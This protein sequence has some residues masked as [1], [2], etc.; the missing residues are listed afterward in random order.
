MPGILADPKRWETWL[1][2]S[3]AMVQ[4]MKSFSDSYAEARQN[5]IESAH[6]ARARVHHYVH[7][8]VVGED[9]EP[10]SCD[11]AVLGNEDAAAAAI[12]ITGTHGVEGYCGSAILHGWFMSGSSKRKLDG[13]KVVLVH[14]I[15]PWSFSHKTRTTENNVDLNRNFNLGDGYQRHNSAY[16]K[17]APFLHTGTFDAR[18]NLEAYRAYKNYLDQHGW[19]IENEM[20]EGQSQRPDGLFY[21]GNSPEWS[22]RTFRKIINEHLG[23][24]KEIGF[25]DWHTGIGSFGEIVYLIFD[26]IGSSEYVTAAGW[27]DIETV[28]Q[29]AFPSG[30]VPKYSGLL[31]RA[32]RQELPKAR[33]AGAV[34]EFGTGDASTIFRADRLD[35][36]LSFEGH[37]DPNYLQFREDY[38]NALC[39]TDLAWRRLVIEEG[40]KIMDQMIAEIHPLKA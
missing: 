33:I 38:K 37:S 15:N 31:C 8:G 18:E 24:A 7:N 10:L 30:T 20:L 34:I 28:D 22:N 4:I 13:T 36:W 19:H 23:S 12:V 9:G 35:R 39:P 11:V 6:D 1:N 16:D 29:C 14:A 40:P 26:E 2:D 17:L 21:V 25:I 32:I 27:W 3:V 5:F